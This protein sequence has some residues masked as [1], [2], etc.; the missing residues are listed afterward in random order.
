MQTFNLLLQIYCKN[1]SIMAA[2]KI[3]GNFLK[4]R[5]PHRCAMCIHNPA[6]Q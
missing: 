6:N 2:I 1:M 3:Y 4:T 5:L